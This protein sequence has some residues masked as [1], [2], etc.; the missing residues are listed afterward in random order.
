MVFASRDL[1]EEPHEAQE[2]TQ[3]APKSLLDLKKKKAKI[4]TKNYQKLNQIWPI[5]A[6]KIDIRKETKNGTTS[7]TPFPHISG[8]QIMSRQKIN[9]R[10]E[11]TASPGI[12]L[13]KRK[14]GIRPYKAL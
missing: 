14:G 4:E 7:E 13:S 8:V 12:I 9:E 11:K 5:L 6:T 3:K 2:N 10:G 1:P